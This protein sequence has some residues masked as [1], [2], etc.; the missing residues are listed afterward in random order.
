MTTRPDQAP[1]DKAYTAP[2]IAVYCD[3]A[4]CRH[5]AECVRGLNALRAADVALEVRARLAS[6]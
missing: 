2:G 4:R 5:Y 1:L 6:E 3:R